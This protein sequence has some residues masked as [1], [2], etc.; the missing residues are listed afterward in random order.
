[1]EPFLRFGLVGDVGTPVS[2]VDG[3][4]ISDPDLYR[5]LLF[6]PRAPRA[7]R[8]GAGDVLVPR[9]R[10]RLVPPNVAARGHA[11]QPR[12]SRR[13]RL[14]APDDGGPVADVQRPQGGR[15]GC[16]ADCAKAADARSL[17]AGRIHRAARPDIG[18][19]PA[20]QVRPGRD[21]ARVR[22]RGIGRSAGRSPGRAAIRVQEAAIRRH[23][24][25]RHAARPSREP[26]D[27][28]LG[29]SRG[30]DEPVQR[31]IPGGSRG[32]SSWTRSDGV[33]V[34]GPN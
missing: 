22:G 28:P 24:S 19:C 8:S 11:L 17:R 2:R 1:V 26:S 14:A 4:G 6:R 32:G 16:G 5:T 23:G 15:S 33:A 21:A 10:G 7:S 30:P 31:Q 34:F 25:R 13:H 27:R 3:P 18:G 9:R 29:F 20:V 12:R